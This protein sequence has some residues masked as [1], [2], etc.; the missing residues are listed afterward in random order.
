MS[1]SLVPVI[2]T[3]VLLSACSTSES[4]TYTLYR[5]S[6]ADSSLRIHVATFDARDGEAYNRENCQIA[7]DLFQKQPGVRVRYWC[8]KGKFRS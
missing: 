2:S 8:E 3:A 7:M 4:E 5:S 6:L 1:K